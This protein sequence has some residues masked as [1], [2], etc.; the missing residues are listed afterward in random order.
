M[1]LANDVLEQNLDR[2]KLV[3][4]SLSFYL[5]RVFRILHSVFFF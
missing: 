5:R 1:T 4:H 3:S 2:T